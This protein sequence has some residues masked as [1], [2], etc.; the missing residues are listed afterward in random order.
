MVFGVFS[1]A[2]AYPVEIRP[3]RRTPQ[4]GIQG[5][6]LPPEEPSSETLLGKITQ[7]NKTV[8]SQKKHEKNA[9]NKNVFSVGISIQTAGGGRA[10]CTCSQEWSSGVPV[11]G[12]ENEVY[13]GLNR[14]PI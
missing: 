1:V 2:P 12:K 11:G 8:V 6:F 5:S 10:I 3:T 14:K 13:I 4:G 9:K 7:K